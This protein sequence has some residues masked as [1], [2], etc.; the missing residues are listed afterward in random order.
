VLPVEAMTADSAA[1]STK[2]SFMPFGI[3]AR[4]SREP[5]S[6]VSP[7]REQRAFVPLGTLSGGEAAQRGIYPLTPARRVLNS[8]EPRVRCFGSGAFDQGAIAPLGT[9]DRGWPRTRTGGLSHDRH[10]RQIYDR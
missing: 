3:P 8:I 10:H 9:H 6:G 2:G 4:R 7:R 1:A 5:R